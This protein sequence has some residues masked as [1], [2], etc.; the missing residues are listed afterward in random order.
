M[1][2]AVFSWLTRSKSFFLWLRFIHRLSSNDPQSSPSSLYHI[3]SDVNKD[4]SPWTIPKIV[5]L[6]KSHLTVSVSLTCASFREGRRGNTDSGHLYFIHSIHCVKRKTVV[7]CLLAWISLLAKR[8]AETLWDILKIERPNRVRMI[9]KTWLNTP[10]PK[11]SRQSRWYPM[12]KDAC[13]HV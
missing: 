13:S 11:H 3:G 4:E 5:L 10:R 7:S 9:K 1:Q 2:H 6:A 12:L 8:L